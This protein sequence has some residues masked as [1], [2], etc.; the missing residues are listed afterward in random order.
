MQVKLKAPEG[1][2]SVAVSGAEYEIAKGFVEVDAAH[3]AELLPHG[4]E[5]VTEED[6]KPKRGR[7]AK[8]AEN[9]EEQASE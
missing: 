6:A 3:V 1:S 4:F 2:C 7:P 8:V 5:V 9:A